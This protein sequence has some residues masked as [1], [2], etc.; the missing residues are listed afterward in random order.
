MR[1]EEDLFLSEQVFLQRL[2][3]GRLLYAFPGLPMF[4]ISTFKSLFGVLD[5]VQRTWKVFQD[6]TKGI[7]V[8]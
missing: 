3:E 6:K 5:S 1:T 7:W 8:P 2:S 4:L